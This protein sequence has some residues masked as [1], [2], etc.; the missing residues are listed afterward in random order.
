MQN[1]PSSNILGSISKLPSNTS[2]NYSRSVQTRKNK[3]LDFFKNTHLCS[4]GHRRHPKPPSLLCLPLLPHSDSPSSLWAN[5]VFLVHKYSIQDKSRMGMITIPGRVKPVSLSLVQIPPL[6]IKG[7]RWPLIGMDTPKGKGEGR[8]EGNSWFQLNY[9]QHG[10][11]N[12]NLTD[13]LIRHN[14]NLQFSSNFYRNSGFLRAFLQSRRLKLHNS[15]LTLMT[16]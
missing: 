14:K 11:H 5:G 13:S 6:E 12:Y 4:P 10:P 8:S 1:F 3:S 9:T 2:E 15:S 16:I 7:R